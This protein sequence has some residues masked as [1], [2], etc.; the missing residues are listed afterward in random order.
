MHARIRM[1]T[2]AVG[3]AGRRG[4][5]LMEIMLVVII[6]AILASVVV[7][8]L[9]GMSTEAK[10]SRAK[11]DLASLRMQLGLFEQRYGHYPTADEGGLMALLERPSTIP[12]DK[13][14]RFGDSE[15]IDPWSNAYVYLVGNS[16][17]DKTRDF[18]LYSCGPDGA[19]DRITGDDIK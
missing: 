7:A 12:E 15:P 16:R 19:D 10:I 2:D 8:N 14:K 11:A 9:G 3:C 18:N 13:W 4:F 5:T 6:I 17:I 1:Q